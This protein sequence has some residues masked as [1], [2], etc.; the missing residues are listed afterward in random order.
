MIPETICGLKPEIQEQLHKAFKSFNKIEKVVLFGSRAKG[1]FKDGSDIDLCLY[2]ANLNLDDLLQV[3]LAID[4]LDL[5]LKVD[6]CIFHLIENKNLLDHIGRV[7][8]S[9]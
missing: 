7:G 1:N 2:G 4:D 5:H 6:L 8:I 9:F 3:S